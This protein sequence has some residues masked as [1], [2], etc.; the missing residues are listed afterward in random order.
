VLAESRADGRS[1][2]EGAFR[3]DLARAREK[4]KSFQL[5]DPYEYVLELA[6]AALAAGAT[7][8]DIQMDADDLRLTFDG[9]PYT[10][11]ELG[12]LFDH[13]FASDSRQAR[14][15]ALALGLASALALRPKLL[16][17]ESGDGVEG[18]R[19]EV[20]EL[21][22]LVVEPLPAA[23]A[24]RG[25]RIHLRERWSWR[26]MR[27][28]LGARNPEEPLLE[29]ACR[30]APVPVRLNGRALCAPLAPDALAG[31][32]LRQGPLRAG[33]RLPRLPRSKS[34]LHV[35]LHGIEVAVH[36]LE[37]GPLGEALVEA[38]I[39]HPELRL[40]AS[41]TDVI[42]DRTY[43]ACLEDLEGQVGRLLGDWLEAE[44]VAPPAARAGRDPAPQD[45]LRGLR[46]SRL[47]LA[48]QLLL[49]E[50]LAAAP[51][52]G[53]RA[54]GRVT[55]LF[56][57]ATSE[58]PV[59][60]ADLLANQASRGV[61][62][63]A[64][65]AYQVR[66]EELAEGWLVIL[67]QPDSPLAAALRQVLPGKLVYVDT[68]LERLER[69]E[70]NRREREARRLPARLPGGEWL[71][72]MPIRAELEL[73]AGK[74][75][76]L[77][78]EVGLP[79][80][81]GVA[82]EHQVTFLREGV[83]VALETPMPEAPFE[84]VLDS[85][86]FRP[87][88]SWDGLLHDRA[89]R[90]ALGALEAARPELLRRLAGILPAP[91]PAQELR[92]GAGQALRGGSLLGRVFGR[93]AWREDRL[94]LAA[95]DLADGLLQNW[96]VEPGELP[97]WLLGWTLFRALD[98]RGLCLA[99][100]RDDPRPALPWVLCEPWQAELPEGLGEELGPGP[101]LNL[102]PR[103]LDLLAAWLG[104]DRLRDARSLLDAAREAAE[105]A[106][107]IRQTRE[108]N[109][110]AARRRARAPRLEPREALVAL[111]LPSGLAAGEVGLVA[112]TLEASQ[113][114]LLHQGLPVCE[115][116]FQAP[117]RLLV[118][119][120]TSGLDE[121][122]V[123]PTFSRVEG[124]GVERVLEAAQA[125][126]PALRLG[127]VQATGL[128]SEARLEAFFHLLA[129]ARREGRGLAALPAPLREARLL[130]S[131]AHG[132]LTLDDLDADQPL[133][134][135]TWP[136]AWQAGP[137]PILR[138]DEARAALLAGVLGV[139]WLDSGPDLERAQK[140][141]SF[142]E[143]PR[144]RPVLVEPTV[145]RVALEGE[146]LEG[147]LGLAEN[148]PLGSES[149]QASI[150]VLLDGRWLCC[151]SMRL[152]GL[153][154]VGVVS[155]EHFQAQVDHEGVEDDE[156]WRAALGALERAAERLAARLVEELHA[157]K[158]G[159][160][161][162]LRVRL[163]M[164]RAL[165][166]ALA[167]RGRGL[168]RAALDPFEGCLAEARFFRSLSGE[169]YS[170]R[171]LAEFLARDGFL[172]VVE[173]LAGTPAAGRL[174]LGTAEPATRWALERLFGGDALRD[175]LA[176][177]ERDERRLQNYLR[178]PRAE[179]LPPLACLCGREVE[180]EVAGL[181]A[182]GELGLPAVG[183][184]GGPG[185]EVRL[186]VEGRLLGTIRLGHPLEGLAELALTGLVVDE[187]WTGPA[188][189]AQLEDLGRALGPALWDLAHD[190][191][192]EVAAR[193]GPRP[194]LLPA[195]RR[196][197]ELALGAELEGL[198]PM[199][200]APGF[201]AVPLFSDLT[202]RVLS[203]GQLQS[204]EAAGSLRVVS[205]GLASG[206]MLPSAGPDE[207]WMV[208]DEED[209]PLL[210]ALLGPGFRLADAEWRA[211]LMNED[212]GLAERLRAQLARACR[213]ARLEDLAAALENLRSGELGG[214]ELVWR[215]EGVLALNTSHPLWREVRQRM[216][217]GLIPPALPFLEAAVLGSLAGHEATREEI[218][219]AL[220][221]LA[222][223][224]ANPRD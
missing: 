2:E 141:R 216:Q 129:E 11:T 125:M 6:R 49:P 23:R 213:R 88:R 175:G 62:R 166:R 198:C 220:R 32:E 94:S 51:S 178:S 61:L 157:G 154:L 45:G 101:V 139:P 25:T 197:L 5:A 53:A 92:A 192:R 84:A 68:E 65:R 16:T 38:F 161:P 203:A 10:A 179:E 96:R 165:G 211:R 174:M 67:L 173:R 77:A 41:R 40:N 114:V 199:P 4:I 20:H 90:Q 100:L 133:R 186:V 33:L 156:A 170:A 59:C 64:R 103:Q 142:R 158:L 21:D 105:A 151:K 202:G 168:G 56:H 42:R 149:E 123:D 206:A 79:R 44:P 191:A 131:V 17:V 185:I 146:G 48:A 91:P 187:G 171:E 71:L 201:R 29:R 188:E 122:S 221:A 24:P 86:A 55:D 134:T 140:A 102:D 194:L 177:L 164:Q 180:L 182:R 200:E 205:A 181:R 46:R 31:L 136:A 150:E 69:R 93:S 120:E 172:W 190:L 117:A 176:E 109:V 70:K 28:A 121:A 27:E 107:T 81:V 98:G 19:L 54:L 13:L 210:G 78:G 124:P 195:E 30:L 219:K 108:R 215:R 39:D 143:Q 137:Q 119:V 217:Q 60:L 87:T 135:V 218:L 132:A 113:A 212:P 66:A 72:K 214:D 99:E 111:P 189:P 222:T 184:E 50:A 82:R 110:A 14:L 74:K 152:R 3:L 34:V 127:L 75:A 155:S 43:T 57:L 58:E 116:A 85:P 183:L 118:V 36:E 204:L 148:L 76:P 209:R 162:E 208:A 159:A 63:A 128:P 207:V 115:R 147:E 167:G 153:P 145:A 12:G 1:V 144:R 193:P 126:L 224:Y 106:E 97:D 47:V 22:R 18:A 138:L 169:S 223:L 196:L 130:P 15:R 104:P 37:Q 26:V 73:G 95:R 52:A 160:I 9:E 35:C 83:L 163:V 89:Y 112:D 8:L 7:D 80:Q